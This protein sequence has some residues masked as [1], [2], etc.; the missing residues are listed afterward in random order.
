MQAWG[1]VQQCAKGP[2]VMGRVGFEQ[3]VAKAEY[4]QRKAT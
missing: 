4:G 1:E 2:H 3:A